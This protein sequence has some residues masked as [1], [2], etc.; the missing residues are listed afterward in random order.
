MK[1]C[2]C[3]NVIPL[4]D[5][6]ESSDTYFIITPFAERG[7]LWHLI[8]KQGSLSEPSAAYLVNQILLGLNYLHRTMHIIHWYVVLFI[9][10]YLLK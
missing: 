2:N 6:F 10:N 5:A 7:D 8:S 4:I 9:A 1:E 3:P